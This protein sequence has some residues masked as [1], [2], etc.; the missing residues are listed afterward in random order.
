MNLDQTMQK[1]QM[2][3]GIKNERT[4][5]N[6]KKINERISDLI[7]TNGDEKEINR[8]KK[9]LQLHSNYKNKLLKRDAGAIAKKNFDAHMNKLNIHKAK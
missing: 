3:L 9:L 5:K 7:N 1:E 6:I 4:D 2:L 8:L